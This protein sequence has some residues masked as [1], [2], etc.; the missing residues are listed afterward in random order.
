FRQI[1]LWCF[2]HC[3]EFMN[4]MVVLKF[5][6]KEAMASWVVDHLKYIT[7][8]EKPLDA[9]EIYLLLNDENIHSELVKQD[10]LILAGREDHFIPFKMYDMQINAL[11]NA[12]SVTGR[13]FTRKEHAQNHCQIG[14]IGLVLDVMVKWIENVS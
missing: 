6:K 7:K 12:K 1:H 4:R 8:K 3:K 13:V 5:E 9:L 14:N 10:V 2:R 11:K